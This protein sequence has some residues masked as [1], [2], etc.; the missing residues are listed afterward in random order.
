MNYKGK[1]EK[2]RSTRDPDMLKPGGK[3]ML[4]HERDETTDDGARPRKV[5]KQALRDLQQGLVDTDMHGERGVEA[6]V[7]SPQKKTSKP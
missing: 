3:I 1:A 6:T 5:M 2:H 4:P 7:D